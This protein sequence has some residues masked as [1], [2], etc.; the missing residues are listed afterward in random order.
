VLEDLTQFGFQLANRRH[1]LNEQQAKV[2]LKKLAIYHACSAVLYE[3]D[4]NIMDLHMNSGI[5]MEE[6]NPL[7]FFFSVGMQESLTTLQND[8]EL[9]SF[10]PL[11]EN[12]NIVERERKVFRRTSN[13]KIHVLCHGDLWINNI[14][15]SHNDKGEPTEAALL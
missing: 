7:S 1:R 11:L 5:D 8:P 14:F 4:P 10:A 6:P 2:V 9:S 12:F 15:L 13:E 3:N